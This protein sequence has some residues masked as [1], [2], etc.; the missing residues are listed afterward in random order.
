M[1]TSIEHI[2]L[3][4]RGT[5]ALTYPNRT[6][7]LE[8][9]T[10]MT[11]WVEGAAADR[12]GR[13]H[14]TTGEWQVGKGIRGLLAD[15]VTDRFCERA[16]LL[17][18]Y[19]LFEVD[20]ASFSVRRSL[21]AGVGKHGRSI[22]WIDEDVIGVSTRYGRAVTLVSTSVMQVVGRIRVAA[23]DAVVAE[24][25]DLI[26]MSF[27]T[28]SARRVSGRATSGRTAEIPRGNTPLRVA[29]RVAFLPGQVTLSE[30]NRNIAAQAGPGQT[31][32]FE[33]ML[34]TLHADGT[35]AWLDPKTLK[36]IDSG[37]SLGAR[38]LL[39]AQAGTAIL[40]GSDSEYVSA[41]DLL[42][43]SPDGGGLT[44][45][46][47]VPEGIVDAM[48]LPDRVLLSNGRAH[49]HPYLTSIATLW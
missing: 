48:I 41:Q 46:V 6:K 15:V 40:A 10:V 37:P 45:R 11:A 47:H 16:W 35:I 12:Y 19:G 32:R 43:V 24:G 36:T 18:S 21:R 2:D 22:H 31:D 27:E 1:G 38:R 17:C 26:M 25:P 44:G 33:T 49:E 8:D 30:R 14:L 9:G 7:L 39:A 20:L 42:V 3:P 13:L 28:G 23:P 29:D 5:P 34:S 4:T